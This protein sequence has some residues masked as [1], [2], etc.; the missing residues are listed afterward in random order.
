MKVQERQVSK[1]AKARG[2]LLEPLLMGILLM[3]LFAGSR[4]SAGPG[5]SA[6]LWSASVPAWPAASVA[7]TP[8]TA[9]AEDTVPTL[10]DTG[11]ISLATQLPRHSL[12][13]VFDLRLPPASIQKLNEVL[14]KDDR[15]VTHRG[16][17]FSGV[18]DAKWPFVPATF[19][20]QGRSYQVKVRFRGWNYDHYMLRKKSWRIKFSRDDPFFG[21]REI[22]VAN[23][24]ERAVITDVF[25]HDLLRDLGQM[26]SDE[27]LVHLRINGEF[28]GVQVVFEQPSTEFLERHERQVGGIFGERMHSENPYVATAMWQQY[29]GLEEDF[30]H[31]ERFR[32]VVQDSQVDPLHLLDILDVD[33]FLDFSAEAVLTASTNPGTHN[34][35]LYFNPV[36]QKFEV[37]PWYQFG[38][39]WPLNARYLRADRSRPVDLMIN[40]VSFKAF[41]NRN[42]YELFHSKLAYLLENEGHVSYLLARFNEWRDR[43]RPDI[44]ADVNKHS[45][46]HFTF[47]NKYFTNEEWEDA[48]EEFKACLAV[49]HDYARRFLKDSRLHA[50][51]SPLSGQGPEGVEMCAELVLEIDGKIPI[52]LESF[53]LGWEEPPG[54]ILF[55][56]DQDGDGVF[57]GGDPQVGSFDAAAVTESVHRVPGL[58]RSNLQMVTPTK[59]SYS[60]GTVPNLD[61]VS[62]PSVTRILVGVRREGSGAKEGN[63]PTL[64][65]VEAS[66]SITGE[67][68]PVGDTP[69]PSAR[70]IEIPLAVAGDSPVQGPGYRLGFYVQRPSPINIDALRFEWPGEGQRTIRILQEVPLE[71]GEVEE[72]LLAQ[73]ALGA[74]DRDVRVSLEGLQVAGRPDPWPSAAP[75][76][77]TLPTLTEVLVRV[78]GIDDAGLSLPR[79][80]EVSASESAGGD[81]VAVPIER[82]PVL[83]PLS[84]RHSGPGYD[85][86]PPGKV[87]GMPRLERKPPTE[88]ITWTGPVQ[89]VHEDIDLGP[90][91]KLVIEPGT[92][93][94]FGDGVSL[95]VRGQIV[96][97]GTAEK[98][99][100]FVPARQG[101]TWGV[102]AV[103]TVAAVENVFSH[104]RF[105]SG[106]EGTFGSLTYTGALSIY[107]CSALVEDSRFLYSAGDDGINC[108]YSESIVR[109]CVFVRNSGDAIDYDFTGGEIRACAFLDNRGDSIDLS[110]ATTVIRDNVITQ[111]G[112]K[113]ISVGERSFPSIVNN[114]IHGCAMGIAVKDS[115]DALLVKNTLAGN[116]VGVSLYVKKSFFGPPRARLLGCVVWGNEQG[117]YVGE[118]SE[119]V[120]ESSVVADEIGG[121]GRF[122]A[123]G[124]LALEPVL[125]DPDRGDL[126]LDE[127][128]PCRGAG[129]GRLLGELVPGLTGT[130]TDLGSEVY[131][132]LGN[133]P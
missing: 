37:L 28:A 75:A 63:L 69:A 67:S 101:G 94:A 111:S 44:Y 30:V 102:V 93:V 88:T 92:T 43:A 128:S 58:L 82:A 51:I 2:H 23:L 34:W 76:P 108:K 98:P 79:L 55:F 35:R 17:V 46:T 65:G 8:A 132:S 59:D 84:V 130:L 45:V 120:V 72:R 10:P 73:A 100:R 42:F 33:R 86:V 29:T 4:E 48:V 19:T 61:V 117:A 116:E 90:H 31:F 110:G 96:A 27:Y 131:I 11:P 39:D 78:E 36:P 62:S 21:L 50:R 56:K 54:V 113:G 80:V 47:E 118:G 52:R 122:N 124:I 109:N 115:S 91:I 89:Q 133:S 74:A 119:L 13:P 125:R 5:G 121:P 24:R 114:S 95:R 12:L 71:T 77:V 68:L 127:S 99:I 6:R 41:R 57:G 126:R 106:S 40:P 16:T 1:F 20:Y 25:E 83:S 14:P 18:S 49:R 15:F 26:L 64:L 85:P 60:D 53:T 129:D 7:T 3:L 107:N 97:Q 104:C 32:T 9:G 105:E 66:N 38:V 81:L 112:D 103:D 70:V 123:D 22:N 87:P